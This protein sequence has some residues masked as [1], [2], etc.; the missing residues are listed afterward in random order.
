M[1]ATCMHCK[2][3]CR[4]T[5]GEEVYPHRIDLH[6]KSFWKCDNC[7]AL[8]G[9]HPNTTTPLGFAAD[10][11][12]RRAR[13]MLHESYLDPIWKAAQKE[14]RNRARRLV[15][16]LLSRKMGL[17][18]ENTHTGKFTIEQCHEARQHLVGVS[19]VNLREMAAK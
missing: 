9:C 6:H 13:M 3:D 1:N 16:D 14:H 17:S 11:E 2:T 10:A 7:G 5:T 4:L 18:A 12:T 15:Y 8:V 19:Y